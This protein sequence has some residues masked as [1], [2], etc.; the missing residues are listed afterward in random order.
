MPGDSQQD[1]VEKVLGYARRIAV[2]GLSNDP[3]S[4]S[5][6]V[7][8]VL[9]DLGYEIVPVNPTVDE[10]LGLRSYRALAEVPGE[11]DVVDVFRRPEHLPAVARD[12]VAA[13]AKALWLQSGLRS[14]EAGAIAKAAGLDFVQDRCLKIEAGS[15]T[16]SRG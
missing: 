5:Y 11:I 7:A 6:Y 16:R 3:G 15:R 8:S 12:A 1:T 10:V 9:T 14:E 4:A 13:G 2:V